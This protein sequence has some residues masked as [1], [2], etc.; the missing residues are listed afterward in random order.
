[1]AAY[2]HGGH[3][4]QQQH[5]QHH[6]QHAISSHNHHGGRSRRQP[7]LAASH[8]QQRQFR[9]TK[10]MKELATEA[11][12]VTAFRSRFEAGRSFD[13]EDDLE[14]CPGLL[15][16]EDVCS[17]GLVTFDR[18]ADNF[19]Q[20]HSIHSASSDRS[21]LSSGSPDSSPMQHIS[22]P[23]TQVTP[24]LSL[25]SAA[26]SSYA[27]PPYTNTHQQLKLHQPSAVRSRNA[28]PIVNPSTGMRVSSPPSSIS[29]GMMQQATAARRW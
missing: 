15:T 20:L 11:P 19:G 2:F 9:G 14:F 22:H 23:S 1:M 5:H 10:S 28:I 4:Q 24:A 13:L 6:Q 26:V 18:I 16:D 27:S 7:R 21:S 29:P 8:N 25:A 12:T 3:Y 17:P